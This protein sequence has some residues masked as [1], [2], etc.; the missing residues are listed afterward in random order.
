MLP[1]EGALSEFAQIETVSAESFREDSKRWSICLGLLDF[2]LGF[3]QESLLLLFLVLRTISNDIEGLHTFQYETENWDWSL[4]VIGSW[5][6][7][8]RHHGRLWV[9]DQKQR[10]KITV[11]W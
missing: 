2:F 6:E 11:V 9:G 8:R 5:S 1:K 10:V 3:H 4:V 7:D